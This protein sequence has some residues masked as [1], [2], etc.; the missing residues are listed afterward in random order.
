VRLWEEEKAASK[1]ASCLR[2]SAG[3]IKEYF[4]YLSVNGYRCGRNIVCLHIFILVNKLI[5]II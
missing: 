5:K 4:N 3:Q 1:F 2:I